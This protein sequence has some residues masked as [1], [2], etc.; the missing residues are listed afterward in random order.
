MIGRHEPANP[1]PNKSGL[2]ES[3][4]SETA[5]NTREINPGAARDR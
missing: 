2:I 3:L 1:R 4:S 5:L